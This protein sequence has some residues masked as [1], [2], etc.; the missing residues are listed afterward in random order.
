MQMERLRSVYHV[1]DVLLH[2]SERDQWGLVINEAVAA[3]MAIVATDVIGA[4]A[5][6][7]RHGVNGLVIRP[8]SAEA[9]ATAI[10]DISRPG[11]ADRFRQ[12]ASG[13]LADWQAAADPIQ[14]FRSAVDH[15]AR[16]RSSAGRRSA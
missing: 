14:G 16:A 9:M 5:D 8:R 1:C 10:R 11:A 4:A 2:P 13:V 6:L 15:F 3:G 7:V 12:C